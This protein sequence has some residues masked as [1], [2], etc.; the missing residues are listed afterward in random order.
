MTVLGQLLRTFLMI[1]DLSE[2]FEGLERAVLKLGGVS[3]SEPDSTIVEGL[4]TD[5][6]SA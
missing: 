5:F 6:D 4:L 3:E 1:R 2:Q